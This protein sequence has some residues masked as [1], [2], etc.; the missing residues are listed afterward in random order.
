MGLTLRRQ[1]TAKPISPGEKEHEEQNP[2]QRH[3]GER[4]HINR[5]KR[6]FILL[7]QMPGGI[8]AYSGAKAKIKYTHIAD[9][10]TNHLPQAVIVF[11]KVTNKNRR[12]EKSDH[13]LYE[14]HQH[15]RAS[16]YH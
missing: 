16:V 7:C 15:I 4:R 1:R 14:H 9:N 8:T 10:R 5:L 13:Q 3:E 6:G 2:N 11:A 12:H